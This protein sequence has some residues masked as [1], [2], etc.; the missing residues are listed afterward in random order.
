V[1]LQRNLLSVSQVSDM[2]RSHEK[3]QRSCLQLAEKGESGKRMKRLRW[4]FDGG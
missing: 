1:G 2:M 4:E 3:E